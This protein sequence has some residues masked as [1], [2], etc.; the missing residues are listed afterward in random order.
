MLKHD[1]LV[2][3][4]LVDEIQAV[5]SFGHDVAAGNLPQQ[6]KCRQGKSRH[7]MAYL[8]SRAGD[9][10]YHIFGLYRHRW[11]HQWWGGVGGGRLFDFRRGRRFQKG[12]SHRT[13]YRG[14][15]L[16]FVTELYLRLGRVDIDID[17]RWG[18]RNIKYR[19]RVLA[20]H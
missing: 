15:N 17:L 19:H 3:G 16:V 6:T 10:M 2:G 1:A 5:R 14:E 20:G 9:R 13:L 8:G 12:T 7:G 18:N 11:L 4:M